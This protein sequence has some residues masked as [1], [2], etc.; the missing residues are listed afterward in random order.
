MSPVGNATAAPD[1][2]LNFHSLHPVAL[3][4]DGEHQN[5]A[6]KR[7]PRKLG[8]GAALPAQKEEVGAKC[9]EMMKQ[10]DTV[11]I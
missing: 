7:G 2:F 3:N 5:W 9:H 6:F 1:F 10:Y 8:I 4:F 11:V